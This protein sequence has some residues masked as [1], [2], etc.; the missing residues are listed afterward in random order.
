MW[1]AL[2]I[3]F[4]IAQ[5]GTSEIKYKPVEVFFARRKKNNYVLLFKL[6]VVNETKK[7]FVSIHQLM[8]S[9]YCYHT[10]I[11]CVH[12]YVKKIFIHHR[13]KI[14]SPRFG[15]VRTSFNEKE[16]K[17]KCSFK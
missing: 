14:T 16:R 8:D 15:F 6:L 13:F 12:Y 2:T 5:S 11:A 4:G 17:K 10:F 1:L 3:F 7:V 9:R